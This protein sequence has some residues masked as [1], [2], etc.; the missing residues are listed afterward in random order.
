VGPKTF[1]LELAPRLAPEK[2]E[3]SV[4]KSDR[5]LVAWTD[6]PPMASG[7]ITE[8]TILDVM[9]ELHANL[10]RALRAKCVS[11]IRRGIA[12]QYVLALGL[13]I[14]L[15]ASANAARLHHSKPRHVIVQ[16]SQ[17]VIPSYVAPN[18]VRIYRDD[19]APGGFRTDHD[20]PPSYDDPS[21]FG[22]G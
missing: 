22:G 5:E 4:A 20:D 2:I 18:G 17:P 10:T 11:A 9:A 7:G 8:G 19:S 6:L 1:T 12:M 21:K 16:S 14:T 3:G 15:C 13:L